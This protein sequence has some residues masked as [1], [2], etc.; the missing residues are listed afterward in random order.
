MNPDSLKYKVADIVFTVFEKYLRIIRTLAIAGLV[1]LIGAN[2]KLAIGIPLLI[3]LG[4]SGCI[5]A[6]RVGTHQ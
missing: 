1:I 2:W 4:V 6:T 5:E 3:I